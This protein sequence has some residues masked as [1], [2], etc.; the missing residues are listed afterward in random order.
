M[1]VVVVGAEV[2]EPGVGVVE[3][4][5]G[6][7]QDGSADRDD[8]P[9]LATSAGDTSITFARNVSV[10]PATD[11]RLTEDS[12]EVAV[13]RPVAPLPFLRPADSAMPGAKR[14]HD[15]RWAAVGNRD[16]SMPT[17]AM[18]T[19]AG[20]VP[21]A[22][23]LIEPHHRCRERGDLGVDPLIEV[24]DVGAAPIN[25]IEHAGGMRGGR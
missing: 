3:K 22:G 13:A 9:L 25:A 16:M 6:D 4:V 10:R 17:S 23:D 7:V 15:A 19:Q 12:G 11:R 21:D 5:P 1:A 24:G 18:I 8:G 14:A 20:G 2:V